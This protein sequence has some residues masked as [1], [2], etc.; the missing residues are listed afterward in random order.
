[1]ATPQIKPVQMKEYEVQQSKYKHIQTCGKLPVRGCILSP[2]GK[3]KT[4]LIANLLINVYDGAF[5][6]CY[7]F[8]PTC[9]PG[10]DTTWDAVRKY[11]YG[12]IK[13]PEDEECFF[14]E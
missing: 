3:G 7:V 5:A 12:E 4:T 6:R 10:L 14:S 11:V 13:T 1:M 9:K 8:S 2:G